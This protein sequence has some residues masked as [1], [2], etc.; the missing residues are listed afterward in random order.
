MT[1]EAEAAPASGG[2]QEPVRMAGGYEIQPDG[3]LPQFDGGAGRLFAA[4]ARDRRAGEMAAAIGIDE[5]PHRS[6][7][8]ASIK[9]IDH[10]NL[11]AV[12]D[13][14]VVYW[15]PKDRNLGAVIMDRPPGPALMARM[16]A[17]REPMSEDALVKQVVRPMT[18]LLKELSDRAIFHGGIRP[19]NIF[20]GSP[21]GGGAVLGE[22]ISRPPAC[23]Q[24]VLMETIPRSMAQPTGRGAGETGDDLYAFG[25]TLLLL[26]LGYNPLADQ[27]DNAIIEL[28]ID[29]GTFPALAAHLRLPPPLAE[30]I[31]GLTSDDPKQRWG[32]EDLIMWHSGRR[33]SP[34]QAQVA[35]KASRALELAGQEY[36]RPSSL[37]M[38]FAKHPREATRL[39]EN[40]ELDRWLR[41]SAADVKAADRLQL[42]VDSA[43]AHGRGPG[44]E[45][46]LVSRVA[47][48]LDPP[49]PIRYRGLSVMPEGLGFALAQAVIKGD[50]AQAVAEIIQNQAVLFWFNQQDEAHASTV[51]KV[52]EM[53]K[54]RAMVGRTNMG[55]GIERVLY[56]MADT[57]PCMSDMVR[58]Y[59]PTKASELL[60]ALE[61]V[62]GGSSRPTVPVDRHIIAFLMAKDKKI[63]DGAINNFGPDRP[64]HQR[65]L[66]MLSLFASLQARSGPADLPNLCDWF[67]GLISPAIDQLHSAT[68][69]K[70]LRNQLNSVVQRGNLQQL[71][72]TVNDPNMIKDDNA[73]FLSARRRFARIGLE[74][75]KIERD[76]EKRDEMGLDAGRQLA[77]FVSSLAS[78]AAVGWLVL[79]NFAGL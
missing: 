39:I 50:G 74:A 73:G 19:T 38:V 47:I 13:V 65:G 48:A 63:S 46:R 15:R 20:P 34:K 45:D 54:M 28:K 26:H 53:D 30:L 58:R 29:R 68:R 37:G 52:Q 66:F 18:L 44:Y 35:R 71:Y 7:I 57:M 49:A 72:Q 33:L 51:P 16:D 42:A 4:R 59:H 69:R 31:R 32:M 25:V 2:G 3:P 36:W 62:A 61:Q 78:T 5:L 60:A 17:Q 12:H 14:G 9:T 22:C 10:P 21:G 56:E 76:L 41:R 23:D 24:P 8:L 67:A 43:S 64:E 75:G 77:A 40:G 79:S 27:D 11:L 70:R 55:Y 1:A 6:D